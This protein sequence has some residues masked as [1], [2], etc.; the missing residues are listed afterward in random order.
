MSFI[1]KFI[2]CI[3][4][5][6]AAAIIGLTSVKAEAAELPKYILEAKVE[7]IAAVSITK[8]EFGEDIDFIIETLETDEI[9]KLYERGWYR[10]SLYLL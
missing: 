5:G 1:R 9:R 10:E 7:D 8:D 2:S 4:V 3:G 6:I